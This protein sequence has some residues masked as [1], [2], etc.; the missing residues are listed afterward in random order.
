ML[1]LEESTS[2][3]RLL[4]LDRFATLPLIEKHGS[5]LAFPGHPR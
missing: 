4:Q 5:E 1:R 2:M 3:R